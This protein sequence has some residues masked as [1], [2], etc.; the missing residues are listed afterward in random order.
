MLTVILFPFYNTSHDP[1]DSAY[2]SSYV[3]AYGAAYASAYT[4]VYASTKAF[5]D[6]LKA[7][8]KAEMTQNPADIEHVKTSAIKVQ[9]KH[10]RSGAQSQTGAQ[11]H[12]AVNQPSTSH[13]IKSWTLDHLSSAKDEIKSIASN[14]KDAASSGTKKVFGK[15]K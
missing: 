15:K 6:K 5:Y 8:H 7:E 14:V 3:A 13:G 11:S 10:M 1:S 2:A 9:E 4:A 12:S